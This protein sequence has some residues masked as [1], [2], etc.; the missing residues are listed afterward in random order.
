RK[1]A[2]QY[3]D[4]LHQLGLYSIFSLSY[5]YDGNEFYKAIDGQRA[6]QRVGELA[7]ELKHKQALLRWYTG[8]EIELS[9]LLAAKQNYDAIKK[10]EDADPVSQV[11]NKLNII[12]QLASVTDVKGTDPY[13][14]GNTSPPIL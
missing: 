9:Q 10:E 5:L 13:P 1:D 6:A 12:P 8:E 2:G 4:K 7:K 11:T 3:L 14:V